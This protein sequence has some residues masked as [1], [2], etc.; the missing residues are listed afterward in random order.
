MMEYTLDDAL[1]Y[2]RYIDNAVSGNG[3]V[4]N[5]G[6]KFNGLTSPLFTY[7]S[8][9]VNFVTGDIPSTQIIISALFLALSC[10]FL[11]ETIKINNL[12]V[13]FAVA[14]A[15][16]ISVNRF[17]YL[18]FGMETMLFFLL[19]VITIYLFFREDYFLMGISSAALFLTRG[20]SIFL[21]TSLIIFHFVL[22]RKF[23]SW[24]IFI[25]PLLMLAANYLFN[26]FYYGE[27]MP[28]TAKAKMW[29][30]DSGLWRSWPFLRI[31]HYIYQD[32]TRFF[33]VAIKEAMAAL[34]ALL[35]IAGLFA[36]IRKSVLIQ[37][38]TLFLIKYTAFYIIFNVPGYLW[39][40]APYFLA[41]SVFIAYGL[42]WLY[43]F[44]GK[45]LKGKKPAVLAVS[46]FLVLYVSFFAVSIELMPSDKGNSDYRKIGLW[47]K[48]NTPPDAKI[49]AVEIGHIG[50][51]SKRYIIDIL[52]LVNPINAELIGKR[53][54]ADWLLYYDP[55]YIFLHDP[56]W[57]HEQGM[58][59]FIQSGRFVK[60]PGFNFS[61]YMMLMKNK[62][63]R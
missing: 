62:T 28:N 38:L 49:A 52:G 17:L 6:E 2:Y 55:D 16:L 61:G 39:Y 47:L 1:I 42:H 40:Y 31:S 5:I 9:A 53:K 33:P 63:H 43:N 50:W 35:A 46:V 30:G 37:V 51:Y 19:A 20:E 27:F 57:V 56:L 10:F 22:K 32:S 3:L 36:G 21:I 34:Y 15:A 24:N 26:H 29:Q 44:A 13:V 25:I 60:V 23:P 14:G 4:Y 54:F 41:G 12:P 58:P 48:D 8:V 45:H 18:T 11:I 7:I 59:P